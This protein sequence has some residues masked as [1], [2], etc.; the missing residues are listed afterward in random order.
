M[1]RDHPEIAEQWR[2]AVRQGFLAAFAAGFVTT[3]F[4][5]EETPA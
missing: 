3:G 2:V 1:R 5:S 4:A